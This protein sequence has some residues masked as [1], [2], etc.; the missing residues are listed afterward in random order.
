MTKK[1]EI[2][3]KYHGD[4]HKIIGKISGSRVSEIDLTDSRQF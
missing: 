3:G 2:W 1:F 4:D